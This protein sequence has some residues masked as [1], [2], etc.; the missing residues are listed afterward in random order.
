[1]TSLHIHHLFCTCDIS[2]SNFS[3]DQ[4]R[5]REQLRIS[6]QIT[7]H[8]TVVENE[9]DDEAEEN[10][11]VV[12]DADVSE[13]LNLLSSKQQEDNPWLLGARQASDDCRNGKFSSN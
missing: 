5:I 3:Q 1:M 7:N 12:D 8:K 4:E 2:F 6:R 9:D 13:S 11:D 10:G